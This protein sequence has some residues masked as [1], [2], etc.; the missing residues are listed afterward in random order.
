MR[1]KLPILTGLACAGV[2]LLVAVAQQ[3]F[4]PRLAAATGVTPS[5]LTTPSAAGG[6]D[7]SSH[8]DGP[9]PRAADTGQVAIVAASEALQRRISV[10]AKVRCRAEIAGQAILGSGLY[11][12][13]STHDRLLRYELR[14]QVAEHVSTYQAV[15]DGQHL[16]RYR[17]TPQS[18]GLERIDL[19]AALAATSAQPTNAALTGSGIAAPLVWPGLG[20]L[21][22]ILAGMAQCFD[23]DA[24][25]PAQLGDLQ[26]WRLEGTW[27]PS[28]LD[29][30][31]SI[32]GKGSAPGATLDWS[33]VP[34]QVPN[35]VVVSLGRDDL[36]P[37]RIEYHRDRAGSTAA[38]SLP[39]VGAR[40]GALV[41]EFYEVRFDAQLDP[42]QFAYQP[43]NVPVADVTQQFI[44][45]LRE[46]L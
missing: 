35:R 8:D 13:G 29:R 4:P 37:Y 34:P 42:R 25:Q 24:P 26:V 32:H 19:A 40:P 23:F 28:R 6:A 16:W 31:G 22:R 39:A 43:G 41:V 27:K 45:S 18:S 15:C 9:R 36:F 2:G 46:G 3:T 20:G 10:V 44:E 38:V 17:R 33:R 21:D 1:Y 5:R 14:L 7:S 12:Q 30:P 11:L